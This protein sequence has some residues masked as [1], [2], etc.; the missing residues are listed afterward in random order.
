MIF[1]KKKFNLFL[2]IYYIFSLVFEKK[3]KAAKFI[4][5]FN[6]KIIHIFVELFKNLKSKFSNKLFIIK[7]LLIGFFFKKLKKAI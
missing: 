6:L 4:V 3:L 5:F 7:I 1:S 2:I